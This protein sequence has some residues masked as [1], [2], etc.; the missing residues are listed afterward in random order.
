MGS[1]IEVRALDS[2]DTTRADGLEIIAGGSDVPGP[3]Q[4]GVQLDP[5]SPIA[6]GKITVK[7]GF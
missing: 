4:C 2:D 1:A 6:K 5:P 7:I 3:N